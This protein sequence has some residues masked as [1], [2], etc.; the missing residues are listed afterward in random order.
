MSEE[1]QSDLE[2]QVLY[3]LREWGWVSCVKIFNSRTRA[4]NEYQDVTVL[5][6]FE[7]ST[8]EYSNL[9]QTCSV[10]IE[11]YEY[12]DS[13]FSRKKEYMNFYLSY[14]DKNLNPVEIHRADGGEL[15]KYLAMNSNEKLNFVREI[16]NELF[17][18]LDDFKPD[19][20]DK[21]KG[22]GSIEL[23]GSNPYLF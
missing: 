10:N 12:K 3:V 22:V 21:I 9:F 19:Y 18:I 20:I 15:T 2:R 1:L 11:K 16:M 8:Y 7:K 17:S 6:N 23:E 4:H 5:F 14:F 13:F